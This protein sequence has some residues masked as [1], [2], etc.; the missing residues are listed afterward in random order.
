MN[1]NTQKTLFLRKFPICENIPQN[2]L[3]RVFY[4]MFEN[5]VTKGGYLFKQNE[6]TDLIHFISKGSV[7][8]MREF[9]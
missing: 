9:T 1:I 5:T 3:T 4:L 7:L 8:Y 2:K 6:K